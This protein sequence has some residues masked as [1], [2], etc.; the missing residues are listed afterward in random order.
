MPILFFFAFLGVEVW[1]LA[2]AL[3]LYGAWLALWVVGMVLL[4]AY[5]IKQQGLRALGQVQR[6][7][8][9]GHLPGERMIYRL[10][11]LLAG[12]FLLVPGFVSDI[13]GIT[14]LMPALR[15]RLSERLVK[16]IAQARPDLK[17]P[18]TLDGE[19]QESTPDLSQKRINRL[20]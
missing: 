6:A 12:V 17:Q 10:L 5:T 9:Q 2:R 15:G 16:H 19:F 20:K 1:L 14:L 4:G 7:A 13:L 11:G 18:V 8:M 3:E